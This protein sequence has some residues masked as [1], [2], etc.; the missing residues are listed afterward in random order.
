MGMFAGWIVGAMFWTMLADR[1]GRKPAT[2]VCGWL[3]ILTSALSTLV[4]SYSAYFA[5]RTALGLSLGGQ[6][7]V[8][9]V[10]TLEWATRRDPS[11]LTFVG[12]VLFSVANVIVVGLAYLG[13]R[14]GIGWREQQLILCAVQALP[15]AFSF[16]VS[17]SPVYLQQSGRA[18]EAE[19]ALRG[20]LERHAMRELDICSLRVT[21]S[22]E[23]GDSAELQHESIFTHLLYPETLC[24][25]LVVMYLWFAVNLM[26]YGLGEP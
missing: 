5:M 20:V 23:L 17:E 24:R 14:S 10:W 21:E 18:D 8:A 26:F 22:A 19:A 11:L 2:L 3:S 16:F 12:N 15:F 13:Q 1:Y 9:Y 6:A 7:A 4:S 25:L